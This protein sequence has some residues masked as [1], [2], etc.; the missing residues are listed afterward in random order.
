MAAPSN[1]KISIIV[2]VYNVEAYLEEC[3]ASLTG[4]TFSDIE[5]ICIDD[6]STDGSPALLDALASRDARIR[7]V[8]QENTGVARARNHALDLVRGEY[9]MFV[10]SDDA[11]AARSCEVLYARAQETG[12]DIVVFGGKTYPTEL[13][14][15]ASF[16]Q[17]EKVYRHDSVDALLSEAGSAP[18]MCN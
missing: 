16:A 18:L 12:A 6:G 11:I 15:D 13:W 2:P 5:I 4:Q 3:L 17:R 14:A 8:H 9:V 7:A 1:P 10:D